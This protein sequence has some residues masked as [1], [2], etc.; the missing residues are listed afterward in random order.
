MARKDADREHDPSRREF[1][2]TFSREALQNAGAVAGAA[3]EIRRT[4]M[5]AA[6]ELLDMNPE[7]PT[8]APT[9]RPVPIETAEASAPQ[10][11]FR[12]PYRFTGTSVVVLDQR[13]LPGRVTTFECLTAADVAA[14]LRSG[15]VTTGPVMGQVAAYGM[16]LAATEAATR[17]DDRRDQVVRV[18][19]DELRASRGEVHVV[20]QAVGR[21][22]SAYESGRDLVH[23]ADDITT[24]ATAAFASIGQ[25]WA[26]LVVGSQ[27]TLLVH[28][29]SGPLACGIVGML[30]AGIQTL[31]DR[32]A[33][34][35]IWVT[36]G[37]PSSE[38]ARLTALG[39]TQLDIV[40]TVIPDSA[41]GWL[42][43]S[44]AV[45]AAVLRGDTIAANG[46]SVCLLG[47]R[48]VA[49]LA[50]DSKVPVYVLAPTDSWDRQAHDVS[51]LV[52]DMRSAAELGSANRARLNPPFDVV[53]A[54]NVTAY[55]SQIS[56]VSPP[57]KEAR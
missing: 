47:S 23:E 12:S 42:L 34:V 36:E 55:V 16:A 14:A 40:H 11:K 51:A 27:I 4:S 56:V 33:Y 2:K 7:T 24:E 53:P 25:R 15:A 10:E 18:A 39:L 19:A 13:D 30:T 5:A 54:R 31:M 21:M 43:A 26:E 35:H 44:R 48:Q 50:A 3:S 22:V 8:G 49:Q 41:T 6:R 1:F 46:E 28:G 37:S 57:F 32:G 29:D 52:L 45:T 9:I 38:G 20:R 17:T